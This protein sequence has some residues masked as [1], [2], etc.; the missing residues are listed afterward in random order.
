[1]C[2]YIYIYIYVY[3]YIYDAPDAR[4]GRG[5]AEEHSWGWA[6]LQ[7]RMDGWINCSCSTDW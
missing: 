5:G 7:M 6:I 4:K 3:I 1:M 2:I